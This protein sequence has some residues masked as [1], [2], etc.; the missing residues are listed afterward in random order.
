MEL[1]K[2]DTS[3]GSWA[4]H[5]PNLRLLLLFSSSQDHVTSELKSQVEFHCDV[6]EHSVTLEPAQESR[7]IR[8]GHR[9]TQNCFLLGNA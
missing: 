1:L 4:P 7:H 5:R 6:S 9:L 8:S 3:F 2:A